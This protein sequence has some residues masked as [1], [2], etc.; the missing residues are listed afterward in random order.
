MFGIAYSIIWHAF[1]MSFMADDEDT[2]AAAIEALK[3]SDEIIQQLHG[4]NAHFFIQASDGQDQEVHQVLVRVPRR[5]FLM[6]L[7]WVLKSATSFRFL[8][9]PHLS[10]RVFEGAFASW[11]H[12]GHG[13]ATE[14]DVAKVLHPERACPVLGP[15]QLQ[16]C[17][18]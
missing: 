13:G 2:G 17:V 16:L 4:E 11:R 14:K 15:W 5:T 7:G 1:Q 10:T 12:R 6:Y 3:P 8:T 9:I 18:G